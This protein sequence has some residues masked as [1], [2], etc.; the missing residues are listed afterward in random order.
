MDV[1]IRRSI[2]SFPSPSLSLLS[3]HM[4]GPYLLFPKAM[5]GNAFRH[6][7]GVRQVSLRIFLGEL[8]VGGGVIVSFERLLEWGGIRS[9][10][11]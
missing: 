8:G 5:G 11:E 4:L 9:A 7:V 10:H 6:Q 1:L 2:L 3:H